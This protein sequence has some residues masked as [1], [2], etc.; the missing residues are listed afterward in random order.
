MKRH[1]VLKALAAAPFTLLLANHVMAQEA[2]APTQDAEQV[3]PTEQRDEIVVTANR[4]EQNLQ[5]VVGGIQV[6]GGDEL[7]KQGADGIED[8]ILKVPGAGMQKDGSGGTKLGLRGI[9]NAAGN[10]SGSF[11]GVSTVG[12]Y[13]NDVPMQGA[14]TLPDLALYD[15]NR[16]EV[17]KGPQ[18]TLYGEGSMG[19]AIKMIVN[20]ASLTE[21]EAKA[22]ATLSYTEEGGVNWFTKAAFGGPIVEDRIGLRLVGTMK[23]E[24]GYVDYTEQGREDANTSDGWSVRGIV[25]GE[26]NA[27]KVEAMVLLDYA[28]ADQFPNV[29]SGEDDLKNDQLERQFSETDFGLYGLTLKYDFG[30]VE[31]T[32][33]TSLIK[34]DK[35]QIY[36]SGLTSS[37]LEGNSIDLILQEELG[38]PAT[39]F[40]ID[41]FF[42]QTLV[43]EEPLLWTTSE[44]N[45]AQELRLMSTG[46]E[47]LD[48]VVGLFYRNRDKDYFGV[49]TQPDTALPPDPTGGLLQ[50]LLEP[51][52]PF[53]DRAY[54]RH[55]VETFE[56]YAVY[57]EGNYE[58]TDALELTLG[59]R[60]FNETVGLHDTF[61]VYWLYALLYSGFGGPTTFKIDL[62]PEVDGF[63]PK[64]SLKW[65]IDDDFMV[66]GLVSRG[67][68]S[69]GPNA[70]FA[71]DVGDPVMDPDYLWNYEA[72]YKTRWLS[73]ALTINGT[74]FYLDWEDI[75]LLKAGVGTIG[76]IPTELIYFDNAGDAR[77][78]G[79]EIETLLFP[80]EGLMLGINLSYL[81]GE[82][83]ETEPDADAFVG[84]P[85]PS[86]PELSASIFAA[87]TMD[88][89]GDV[90]GTIAGGWQYIDDMNIVVESNTEPSGLPVESYQQVQI[91]LSV[92][93]MNW[94]V[95]LF[96]DNLLDERPQLFRT[97][98]DTRRYTTIGRPR[99]GGI[100]ARMS[101]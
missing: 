48:W 14:G 90:T 65:Q 61:N 42:Q 60:Y 62:E 43:N 68:R 7:E 36:R 75:Q 26:W 78:L 63:L 33:V 18:G 95:G 79:A 13:L 94:G 80:M 25:N 74:F 12:L 71:F 50:A 98:L 84:S 34:A 40:Q 87:Y 83:T 88:L 5:E 32:S 4:R 17:L 27:F 23:E 76:A 73:G 55:G 44:E 19:G 51:L 59:L 10:N 45:F 2:E 99:T 100:T 82:I 86:M 70:N 89:W 66:Y 93:G 77:V 11:D 57:A 37:L 39:G 85:L 58:L 67:F 91:H 29:N 54:D 96:V 97:L 16:V 22:D 8:Y 53:D 1:H 15:L 92:D 72:G 24:S 46:D 101:F 49:L 64:A 21:Y 30:P 6:F 28:R 31:L 3:A 69:A 41:D 81:D 47:R 56:Q 35:D 9:S 20:H 38:L 52:S